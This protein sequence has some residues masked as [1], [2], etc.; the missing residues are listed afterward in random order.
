MPTG[1]DS[2]G[3][4]GQESGGLLPGLAQNGGSTVTMSGMFG[5]DM[6]SGSLGSLKRDKPECG[7]FAPPGTFAP[8][9]TG[10]TA[11]VATATAA[12]SDATPSPSSPSSC[13]STTTSPASFLSPS[14]EHG[15]VLKQT[16]SGQLVP[17]L[18][19]LPPGLC[20]DAAAGSA[21]ADGPAEEA[22]LRAL[23]AKYLTVGPRAQTEA[24]GAVLRDLARLDGDVDALRQAQ[25][26]ALVQG[27]AAGVRAAV[28]RAQGLHAQHR[29]M[30]R[31]V[32]GMESEGVL[33]PAELQQAHRIHREL[34]R[35]MEQ[36]SL[37]LREASEHLDPALRAKSTG[38][39]ASLILTESPFPLVLA[40]GKLL[41]RPV[42]VRLLR[43]ALQQVQQCAPF[44]AA[45]TA[46]Q[47]SRIPVP[48]IAQVTKV[49]AQPDGVA[50]LRVRLT[51]GSRMLPVT[52][53]VA[54]GVSYGAGATLTLETLASDP[55]V[56]ITNESQFE[57]SNGILLQYLA[58]R[59]GERARWGHFANVVHEHFLRAT[60]QAA[61]ITEDPQSMAAP[62]GTATGTGT[63]T[64]T[65]AECAVRVLSVS[66]LEYIHTRFFRGRAEVTVAQFADFWA[67]FGKLLVRLRSAR[68][69]ASLW[70]EGLLWAFSSRQ[71]I[72]DALL[73][74]PPGTFVVRLSER[75]AGHFAVAYRTPGRPVRHYLI[76]S[77][78]ISA[79]KTL[80]DFL[81]EAS[82]LTTILRV[83]HNDYG[84]QPLPPLCIPIEKNAALARFYTPREA[85]PRTGYDTTIRIGTTSEAAPPALAAAAPT[86][87]PFDPTP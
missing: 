62:A 16:P 32:I 74:Q 5:L 65:G 56:V 48:N 35:Q 31:T 26:R 49:D 69:V 86:T 34:D 47:S 77:E 43:G 85:L 41:E 59:N 82:D 57:E 55:F 7:F 58:F 28:A 22:E 33:T 12:T 8:L 9:D 67:W 78:E 15:M 54:M 39:Y 72:E 24:L 4:P 66:E 63:G 10:A 11:A 29:E 46:E 76:R 6:P 61:L 70:R 13:S 84:E 68:Q 52:L 2:R 42:C 17:G 45:T 79:Q 19:G 80:P 27:D 36:V 30:A 87:T 75:H 71:D 73:R 37:Y 60:K 50:H 3:L 81:S 1:L 64:G 44:E 18:L 53:K 40:K 83:L 14:P 21:G 51:N 23:V 38:C 25:Q 20:P